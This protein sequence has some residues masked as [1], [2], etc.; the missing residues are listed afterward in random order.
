MFFF[1]YTKYGIDI[2]SFGCK[3]YVFLKGAIF[4]LSHSYLYLYFV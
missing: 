3:A 2:I 4:W 1:L